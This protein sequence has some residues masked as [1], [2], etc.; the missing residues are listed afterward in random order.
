MKM[1]ES[2]FFPGTVGM[3]IAY[4]SEALEISGA[5]VIACKLDERKS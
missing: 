1:E 2:V 4:Q 5:T 3:K